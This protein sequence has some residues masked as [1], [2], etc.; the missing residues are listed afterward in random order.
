M[1]SL[2]DIRKEITNRLKNKFNNTKVFFDNIENADFA[3]FYIEFTPKAKTIDD[4]YTEYVIKIDID[5]VLPEDDNGKIDRRKLY[6]SISIIDNLFRPVLKVKDRAF[7]ILESS[8]NITDDILHFSFELD[9][10]DCLDD[11]EI[12]NI[13]YELM[14]IL[15]LDWEENKNE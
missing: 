10:V 7:T 9:F 8:T 15:E 12:S 5:Y 6:D 1:I 14:Q 4:I 11:E 13:K 2:A 3:Y